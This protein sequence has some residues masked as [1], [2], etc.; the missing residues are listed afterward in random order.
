MDQHTIRII[1]AIDDTIGNHTRDLFSR[2]TV[3]LP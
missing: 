1:V 3:G 2:S